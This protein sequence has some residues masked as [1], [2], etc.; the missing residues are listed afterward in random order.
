[1]YNV[2]DASKMTL[3]V[4]GGGCGELSSFNDNIITTNR[5]ECSQGLKNIH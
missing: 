4:G 5:N 1:M 2:A 3:I